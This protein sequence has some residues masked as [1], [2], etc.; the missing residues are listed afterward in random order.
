M[1]EALMS[2][3]QTIPQSW[4]TPVRCTVNVITLVLGELPTKQLKNT[5]GL[6]VVITMRSAPHVSQ[7][8][9]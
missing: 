3:S 7:A 4:A 1:P 2:C 8:K 6:I 5:D 9:G